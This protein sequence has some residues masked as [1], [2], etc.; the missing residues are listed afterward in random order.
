MQPY[1]SFGNGSAMRVSPVGYAYDDLDTVL[2]EAERSAVVTHNHSE[3]IKGAQ[4]VSAA[5]FQARSGKT[6]AEIKEYIQNAYGYD[7]SPTLDSIR[8][9]YR[10]DETCQGSVSQVVIAFLESTG[11]EDA[12]RKAISIGGDS[13]TIACITGSI[14]QAY[15]GG[16]PPEI[17]EKVYKTLDERLGK[18]TRLFQEKFCKSNLRR[19]GL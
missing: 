1:N 5:I 15:Y 11:F 10:F 14:A 3:G 17:E 18:I 16:I 19:M 2:R 4:A 6:K 7:L 9:T 12:I 8:P 13:D